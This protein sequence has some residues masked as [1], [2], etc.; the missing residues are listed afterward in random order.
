MQLGREHGLLEQRVHEPGGFLVG[1]RR[2]RDRHGVRLATA[3]ARPTGKQLRTGSRDDQQRHA[4]RPVDEMV[5]EFEQP[6][7][8]PVEVLEDEHERALLGERLEEATP[9]GKRLVTAVAGG[10]LADQTGQH[11]QVALNPTRVRRLREDP[12]NRLMQLLE[13]RL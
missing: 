8:C 5:N 11:S 2:K 6:I 12:V 13:R 10:F 1:Q 4:A 7:V 9:G 3:P